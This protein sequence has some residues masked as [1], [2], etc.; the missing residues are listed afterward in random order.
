MPTPV[1]IASNL[2]RCDLLRLFRYDQQSGIVVSRVTRGNVPA[3]SIVGHKHKSGYCVVGIGGR[4]FTL[5]RIIW[6]MMTGVWPSDGIDH[7]DGDKANN[8]WSNLREATSRENNFHKPL[9][10]RNRSGVKGV[11]Y[12]SRISKWT[13]IICPT[14]GKKKC[15]RFEDL[16]SAA[17]WRRQQ[18]VKYYGDFAA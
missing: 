8:R 14:A 1:E 15:K 10:R 17:E 7:I 18:A 13:A 11:W 4:H 3:G 9:C 2:T 12:D 5:H 16:A 6:M